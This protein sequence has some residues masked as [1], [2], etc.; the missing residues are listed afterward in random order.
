MSPQLNDVAQARRALI[1]PICDVRW[2]GFGLADFGTPRQHGLQMYELHFE[3]T[4]VYAFN[5]VDMLDE[6][7][8]DVVVGTASQDSDVLRQALTYPG[9]LTTTAASAATSLVGGALIHEKTAYAW[10]LKDAGN[11]RLTATHTYVGH[12]ITTTQSI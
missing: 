7:S 11:I 9:N 8:R 3:I 10:D 6:T 2:T 5:R 1:N 12:T 4:C